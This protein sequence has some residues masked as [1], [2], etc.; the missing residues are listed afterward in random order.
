MERSGPPGHVE[1]GDQSNGKPQHVKRFTRWSRASHRGVRVPCQMREG[2][3]SLLS[4][5]FERAAVRGI[6]RV[7]T[8]DRTRLHSGVSGIGMRVPP[9]IASCEVFDRPSLTAW[10]AAGPCLHTLEG[11]VRAHVLRSDI[12]QAHGRFDVKAEWHHLY[13]AEQHRT[14]IGPSD[15]P[16]CWTLTGYA[17]G[18]STA[19]FGREVFYYEQE[20]MGK[21]DARCLVIGRAA[22]E[23]DGEVLTVEG[24]LGTGTVASG[25]R[26][27]GGTPIPLAT[28]HEMEHAYIAEVLVSSAA[29]APGLQGPRQRRGALYPQYG[30]AA[31][32]LQSHWT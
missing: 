29:W 16:V 4:W 17:S 3:V 2:V 14:H 27:K 23:A 26:Y 32:R 30:A 13:E 1:L 22:D 18:H 7:D 21:G 20:C 10:W 8:M 19:V 11:V 28:L 25:R 6:L 12:D 9:Q 5:L 24:P 15:A 31:L